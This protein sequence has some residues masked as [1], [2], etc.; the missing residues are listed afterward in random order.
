MAFLLHPYYDKVVVL[1]KA[2]STHKIVEWLATSQSSVERIR[3]KG[4]FDAELSIGGR[5]KVISN[6][7][8]RACVRVATNWR[9]Q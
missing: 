9:I 4:L 6:H 5:P 8:R 7:F 1:S 2:W 3:K